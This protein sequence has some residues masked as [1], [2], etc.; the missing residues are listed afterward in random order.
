VRRAKLS[1]SPPPPPPPG[2]TPPV[3][4]PGGP[5]NATTAQAI[6]FNGSGSSD[7]DGTITAYQWN[8]GDSTTGTGVTPTHAY[9]SPGTYTVTLTVTDNK[10]ATNSA[11]TTATITAP[12]TL[13]AAP[14]NLTADSFNKGQ[15]TLRWTDRSNN[16]QSFRI[17]RSTSSSS[18]FVEIATVGA[19]VTSYTNTGL[20]HDRRYYY[21][22]RARNTAGNSAYSNI[23]SAV[24]K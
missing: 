10:G 12:V 8:F 13:P 11:S 19:N 18:G 23:D 5:Y 1:N 14:T 22:V 24:I 2:N 7:A 9:S 21:R 6:Q 4:K 15:A 20:T 16:E 3:A 17:E